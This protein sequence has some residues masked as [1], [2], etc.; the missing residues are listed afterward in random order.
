MWENCGNTKDFISNAS[1]LYNEYSSKPFERS[2]ISN[3][4][5]KHII[6]NS[7]IDRREIDRLISSD[8]L[9]NSDKK[10]ILIKG[11]SKNEN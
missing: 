9:K 11:I 7:E 3:I 2:L 4:A 1:K 6:N 5:Y 10:D 8:I